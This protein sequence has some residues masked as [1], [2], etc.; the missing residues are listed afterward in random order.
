VNKKNTIRL[1]ESELKKVITESVKKILQENLNTSSYDN[2]NE[3]EYV[4]SLMEDGMDKKE[5]IKTVCKDRKLKKD[6]VYKQVLD[7]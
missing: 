3:R 6:V 7:L 4:I 5:A 2:L 1:T